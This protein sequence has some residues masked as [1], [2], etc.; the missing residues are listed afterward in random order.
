MLDEDA[1]LTLIQ[2]ANEKARMKGLATAA[3]A[4][5]LWL[6]TVL[7]VSGFTFLL[8]IVVF[9]F[10][11][12]LHHIAFAVLGVTA[13]LF[14]ESWRY[15][16]ELFDWSYYWNSPSS[17]G[18]YRSQPRRGG[19]PMQAGFALGQLMLSAP[20]ATVSAWRYLRQPIAPEPDRLAEALRCFRKLAETRSQWLP[21][22]TF[23]EDATGLTYLD[24][25]DLLWIRH[26]NDEVEVKLDATAR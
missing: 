12:E 24:H 6:V 23:R 11:P 19:G 20:R 1:L 15:Q 25:A 16:R 3:G 22:A 2:K 5:V 17:W 10:L 26:E 21:A 8:C 18:T 9:R 7:I 14:I 4:F 13:L